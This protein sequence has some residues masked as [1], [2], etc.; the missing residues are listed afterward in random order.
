MNIKDLKKFLAINPDKEGNS[1]PITLEYEYG[2]LHITYKKDGMMVRMG[3][4][5]NGTDDKW[6]IIVDHAY[7]VE[8]I[9]PLKGKGQISIEC[10]EGDLKISSDDTSVIVTPWGKP[11]EAFDPDLLELDSQVLRFNKKGWEDFVAA[12]RVARLNKKGVNPE[13]VGKGVHCHA[14]GEYGTVSAWSPTVSCCRTSQLNEPLLEDRE[15][16]IPLEAIDLVASMKPTEVC[17]TMDYQFKQCL[18]ETDIGYILVDLLPDQYP[19]HN[20]I[21][22]QTESLVQLKRKDL[23]DAVK[24]AVDAGAKSITLV[25]DNDTVIV[26]APKI[27]K[28]EIAV[29]P[30][31]ERKKFIATAKVAANAL[32]EALKAVSTTK[33]LMFFPAAAAHSLI[34]D[35]VTGVMYALAIT[36]KGVVHIIESAA[37]ALKK[38]EPQREVVETGTNHDGTPYVLEAVEVSP[39]QGFPDPK[40]EEVERSKPQT[41]E[42]T[43]TVLEI[44]NLRSQVKDIVEDINKEMLKLRSQPESPENVARLRELSTLHDALKGAVQEVEN[45]EHVLTGDNYETEFTLEGLREVSLKLTWWGGRTLLFLWKEETQWLPEMRLIEP[46]AR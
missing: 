46:I 4:M 19:A 16:V 5:L 42:L 12:A 28:Q 13:I 7:L 38:P 26:E 11:I 15:F 18:I 8:A 20:G 43:E 30:D 36:S 31:A 35:T 39:L 44:A 37:D 24:T 32:L 6:S 45:V 27:K 22:K 40:E 2:S 33:I 14:W 41:D 29:E 17:F 3:S 1:S 25:F 34:I 9:A 23:L 21:Q 10:V